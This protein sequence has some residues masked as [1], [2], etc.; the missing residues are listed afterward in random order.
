MLLALGVAAAATAYLAG[1]S[2]L[3]SVAAGLLAMA[4][5]SFLIATVVVVRRLA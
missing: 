3:W 5:P 2:P 1:A 4:A